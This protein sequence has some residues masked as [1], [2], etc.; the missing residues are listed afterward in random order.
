MKR[1]SFLVCT[2]LLALV[3]SSCATMDG[4]MFNTKKLSSYT[5]PETI[6]PATARGNLIMLESGTNK[7]K[8]YGY[9]VKS[10]NASAT[11]PT[12]FYHHGNALN[13]EAY[14]DRMEIFYKAGYNTFIYDY[15]GYGMS[16]GSSS[17]QGLEEDAEAALAYVLSR[18]DVNPRNIILYGY[19][20]GGIPS[21]YLASK[22][23]TSTV[24]QP[25]AL[26][27]EA[28]Y[29]SASDLVQ[30]GSL[31]DMPGGFVMRDEFNNAERLKS[32]RCPLLL[33]HG[34][35][36]DF[37]PIERHGVK[38]WAN[39]TNAAQPKRFWRIPNANHSTIPPTVGVDS[40]IKEINTYTNSLK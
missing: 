21:V 35:N 13:I 9:F 22:Y 10:P 40:F 5:L 14:W 37:I 23:A 17:Q 7:L 2:L 30:S 25:R 27:T 38:N 39:A 32:V 36:D 26:I 19:S 29:A 12:I 34:E 3:F 18:P 8:I 16:E 4:F 31:V 15:R 6:I 20:L 1:S 11:A 33:M 24:F 28:I